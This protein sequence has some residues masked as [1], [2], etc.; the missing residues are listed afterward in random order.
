MGTFYGSLKTGQFCGL[1]TGHFCPLN[2][3]NLS[4]ENGRKIRPNGLLLR[5]SA[6]VVEKTFKMGSK[7]RPN[8]LSMGMLKLF[9]TN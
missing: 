6:L 7:N 2:M 4:F 8:G 3:D 9:A 1:K 5:D